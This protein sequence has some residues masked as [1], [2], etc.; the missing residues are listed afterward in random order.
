LPRTLARP[1]PLAQ[2]KTVVAGSGRCTGG[3]WRRSCRSGAGGA[4]P[5]EKL[6]ANDSRGAAGHG[7][8][9][10]AAGCP[11]KGAHRAACVDGHR[12]V[13]SGSISGVGGVVG[14]VTG[15]AAAAAAARVLGRG[16]MTYSWGF[17]GLSV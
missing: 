1:S 7:D 17:C 5:T 9:G 2:Q 12:L 6:G 16:G 11:A 4:P 15:G 10:G 8:H 13:G 3:R 14:C